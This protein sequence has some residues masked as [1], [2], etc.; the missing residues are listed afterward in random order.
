MEELQKEEEED[1]GDDLYSWTF[2]SNDL[3]Q[4]IVG[5]RTASKVTYSYK[6]VDEYT[7]E[8]SAKGEVSDEE[9]S[10]IAKILG[11]PANMV[12]FRFQTWVKTSII[13]A[14]HKL[15]GGLVPIVKT[16]GDF[17]LLC[18]QLAVFQENTAISL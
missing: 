7:I 11:V 5:L 4:L 2:E 13:K 3:A 16:F 18:F 17:K 9:I 10:Q 15:I 12:K 8:I 14:E 1:F 6:L